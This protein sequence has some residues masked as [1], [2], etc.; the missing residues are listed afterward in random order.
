MLDVFNWCVEQPNRFIGGVD[1]SIITADVGIVRDELMKNTDKNSFENYEKRIEAE[2]EN[3]TI[4]NSENMA[5]KPK[6]TK[7]SNNYV[8][9][10]SLLLCLLL[11]LGASI[12]SV[13][14]FWPKP[15]EENVDDPTSEVST[16][17]LTSSANVSLKDMKNAKKAGLKVGV[18]LYSIATSYIVMF[19]TLSFSF[20]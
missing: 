2:F 19:S 18:Y 7:K 9:M 6:K 10:L 20:W 11:V 17:S 12:F 16:F 4:F 5:Q 1:G 8:K 13:I 3:S 14:K 15:V